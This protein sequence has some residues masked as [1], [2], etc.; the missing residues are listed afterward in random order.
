MLLKLAQL[1]WA[2]CVSLLVY[3]AAEVFGHRVTCWFMERRKSHR[4]RVD[5]VARTMLADLDSYAQS[6]RETLAA[7]FKTD[8]SRIDVV[9]R[10]GEVDPADSKLVVYVDVR[11]DGQR[12]PEHWLNLVRDIQSAAQELH[13]EKQRLGLTRG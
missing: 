5:L 4:R 3:I 2:P 13:A 1:L 9:V 11:L 7:L 10:H 8:P 12:A 6:L